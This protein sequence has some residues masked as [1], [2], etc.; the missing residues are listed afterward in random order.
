M[1]APKRPPHCGGS[2][3]VNANC[4]QSCVL[5]ELLSPHSSVMIWV[6]KPPCNMV[7]IP[8]HPSPIFCCNLLWVAKLVGSIRWVDGAFVDEDVGVL[9]FGMDWAVG[10]IMGL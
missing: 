7:S 3:A 6:G 5:P 8:L 2:W 9:M 4:K 10:S 1:D